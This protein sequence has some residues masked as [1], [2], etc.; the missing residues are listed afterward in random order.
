[1]TVFVQR[2]GGIITGV[3]A[4]LQSYAY[5]ALEDDNAEVVAFLGHRDVPPIT[6][7][8]AL[9]YLLSI[10]K[11]EADVLT[12]ISTIS[13]ATSR[14]VAEIEWKYRQPFHHGHPLFASLGPAVGISDMGAAFWV[15][16]VL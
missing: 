11:T 6:K 9:L 7:A 14:A 5:E 12:A 1:M 8:Q 2:T 4:N 16:S 3:Y 13:D 10:G 15:A